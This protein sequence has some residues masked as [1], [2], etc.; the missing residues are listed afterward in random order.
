M[1]LARRFIG[2][3]IPISVSLSNLSIYC[4]DHP[5]HSSNVMTIHTLFCLNDMAC[6]G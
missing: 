4:Q 6:K 2:C 3:N 5:K 1:G